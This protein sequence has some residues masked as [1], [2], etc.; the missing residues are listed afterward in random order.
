[1]SQRSAKASP[2]RSELVS[3]LLCAACATAALAA[4]SPAHG[5]PL[6]PRASDGITIPGK[7]LVTTDDASATMYNPANLA[8]LP[9]LEGRFLGVHTGNEARFVPRGYAMDIGVPFWLFGMGLR[10]DW[11]RPSL[12]APPPYAYMGQRNSFQWVRWGAAVRLGEWAALGST[13]AWSDAEARPLDDLFSAS[14]G[15]SLRPSRFV[16]GAV[17]LRDYNEP[18]NDAGFRIDRSVDFGAAIRPIDGRQLLE[19]AFE[20]SYRTAAE[21]WVPQASASVGIPHVGRLRGGVQMLDPETANVV[22]SVGLEL[23]WGGMQLSGGLLAGSALTLEGTGM[24]AGGAVRS[25]EEENSLPLPSR[26]VRLRIEQTPKL[27]R[28]TALLRQLWRL[29]D[30]G[31]V[32]GVLLEL[33]ASP[34]SS[35]ALTEELADALWLLRARGKKV[36]CHLED[37][38][39]R[40]L[41]LCAAANRIGINP[42]GGT[43]FAGLASRYLYFGG[44]LDK[45]GVQADFVRI[46]DHKLAAE[47]F[48]LEGSTP[49]GRQ[50]H[51]AL[52]RAIEDVYL[53][54]IA[55]GRPMDLAKARQRIAGGPYLASEARQAGLVDR[56]VY[57]DEIDRF[58][59][60]TFDG[61]V[62]MEDLR[63][64]SR[65]DPYWGEPRKIAIV[66]LHG[67]MIDGKSVRIPFLGIR[68]A[69]SYTVADALRRAREDPSVQAVV[70]RIESGGG[71]SLAAD[72][73]LREAKLLADEKPLVVS[74]GSRAASGGYYAAVAGESIYANR[75][76]LTGSIGIFY[77]KVDV[78]GLLRKLGIH[79]EQF[80][81][82][83]RADLESL[84]RPFTDQERK[85]LGTKVK[86]FYDLFVGR[87]AEHRPLSPAEV[88]AVARGRV[89]IGTQAQ[90]QQLVDRIGGLRQAIG[91]ARRLAGL[92][93][94][95]TIV[96]LP[97][98]DTTLLEWV[99]QAAGVP[100]VTSAEPS[101]TSPTA[102][103][104][105]PLLDVARALVPFVIF[106]PHKP[107]A[108]IELDVQGP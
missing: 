95:T 90:Q 21:R 61:P 54:G 62:L 36:I 8:F 19:L 30:D 74:M 103:M 50:D 92:P 65:R 33:R 12:G 49:T 63:Q 38:D 13:L 100:G 69:G 42:A 24:Y 14:A 31:E 97:E 10:V 64:P 41:Y 57:E 56:L 40:S 23:N 96:E 60:E 89:F 99:M 16:S 71:S 106:E 35:L 78:T 1:M 107:L 88:D 43:R 82:G 6:P 18:Q 67:A 26:V 55:R 79:T 66:Y 22:A 37:A 72:V 59:E 105:P 20:T 70:F 44:L 53:Q 32:K 15:L 101:A 77:G 75:S 81:T 68:L 5:Q 85:A 73:I 83:P 76:S 104:P 11:V 45:L 58:V 102:W 93:R 2:R 46:G 52:L 17:V 25:F 80:R 94:D 29:A 27:R 87:V 28:H 91:H 34:A 4:T 7:S 108:R 86:Q 48:A 47:T 98:E 84:F 51:Q 39:G 9:G 3:G